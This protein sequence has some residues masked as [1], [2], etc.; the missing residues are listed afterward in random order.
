MNVLYFIGNGFDLN[1]GLKTRF[2]DVLSAYICKESNN[3][4]LSSFKEHINKNFNTWAIFEEMMGKYTDVIKKKET[5]IETLL[6]YSAC[7][8]DF[9]VFLKNYLMNEEKKVN[10]SDKKNIAKTIN[11]SLFKFKQCLNC[12][13]KIIDDILEKEIIK[14]S[15]I[16]FNYTSVFDNC[17]EIFKNSGIFPLE[18]RIKNDVFNITRFNVLGDVFHIHGT[19]DNNMILG[20][21]DIRQIKNSSLHSLEKLSTYIKPIANDELENHRNTDA[22]KLIN[23]ADIYCIFGMSLGNTDKKWWLEIGM[24]LEKIP[25]KQLIIYAYDENH[26]SSFPENTLEAKDCYKNIFFNHFKYTALDKD[27]IKKNIRKNIHVVMNGDIF[28]IELLYSE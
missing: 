15:F 20:V 1:I 26:D 5:P 25:N 13:P 2:T 19:L 22:I 9:R 4:V 16:S 10:Y 7:I 27:D 17:L 14:F 3:V 18:K 12:D 23:E 28:N 21:N 6:D 11:D 24:Q 8:Y